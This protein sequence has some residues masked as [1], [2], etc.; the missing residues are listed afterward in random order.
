MESGERDGKAAGAD[1]PKKKF[2]EFRA[3]FF[4]TRGPVEPRPAPGFD[5]PPGCPPLVVGGPELRPRILAVRPKENAIL[6]RR[7]EEVGSLGS[8]GNK[9][10]DTI[11]AHAHTGGKRE[12]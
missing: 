9:K 7:S 2:S 11:H 10:R 3:V 5:R 12:Q 1:G 6:P 8:V 4:G